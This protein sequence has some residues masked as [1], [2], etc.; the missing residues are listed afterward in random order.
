MYLKIC[1]YVN[2]MTHSHARPH[3][4]PT[5]ET[6][7]DPM[8]TQPI[9]LNVQFYDQT[10]A[11]TQAAERAVVFP[12][13]DEEWL[14]P[15]RIAGFDDLAHNLFEWRQQSPSHEVG[16]C[17]VLEDKH[18]AKPNMSP[19]ES[20]C[21]FIIVRGYLRQTGWTP[22]SAI[23][24]HVDTTKGNFDG[25]KAMRMKPYMQTLLAISKTMPLTS[26]IPSREPVHFYQALLKGI[27]VEPGM[28]DR[29]YML[30]IHDKK[31][32]GNVA[33]PLP[34]DDAL[35]PEPLDG[36]EVILALPEPPAAPPTKRAR[37][38][39][40]P[41]R[42]GAAVSTASGSAG[43]VRPPLPNVCPGAGGEPGPTESGGGPPAAP[44]PPA[45][46][47]P[48]ENARDGDDVIIGVP[49]EQP[50]TAKENMTGNLHSMVPK[51]F[52]SNISTE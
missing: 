45:Q 52:A 29:H 14:I 46:P 51:S 8:L 44:T 3:V 38:E 19:L 39:A 11:A 50:R 24:D 37:T 20:N 30:V 28:S 49:D 15:T 2:D 47:P 33:E 26:H 21:P 18:K 48:P 13:A 1:F 6:A 40:P 22:V 35:P 32:K 9:C 17:M 43:P 16:G 34:L 12:Q 7:H 31:K 27:K 10:G 41:A 36:E 23:C 42:R 4:M 5:V 25:A